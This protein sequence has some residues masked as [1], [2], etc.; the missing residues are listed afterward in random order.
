MS[1]KLFVKDEEGEV[2]ELL[3]GDIIYEND[4]IIWR[5]LEMIASVK[6]EVAMDGLDVVCIKKW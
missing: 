2:R 1:G 6:I 5:W 4:T 3:A